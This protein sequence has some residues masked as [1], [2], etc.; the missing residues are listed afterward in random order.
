M[1]RVILFCAV[2]SMLAGCATSYYKPGA[3]Q[4]QIERDYYDC[5]VTAAGMYTGLIPRQIETDTCMK[6]RY[7]YR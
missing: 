7:G 3:S 1:K 5:R 6:M 4:E 2:V